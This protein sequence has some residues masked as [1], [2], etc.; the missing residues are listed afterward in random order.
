[1]KRQVATIPE[2]VLIKGEVT[3]T[4]DLTVE[5]RVEGKIGLDRHALTIGPNGRVEAEVL[6]KIV[7]VMGKV[8]GDISATDTI[9]ILKTA[10][11][12]GAIGAPRVGIE[13]G[14]SFRGHIDISVRVPLQNVVRW[15]KPEKP[16]MRLLKRLIGGSTSLMRREPDPDLCRLIGVS[17][18]PA[19]ATMRL[20]VESDSQRERAS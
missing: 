9:N 3:A 4:Q 2:S 18:K 6:A 11:V 19:E 7:N 8:D 13:E 14:A 10:T 16:H 15:L 20:Q 12:D 1:M 5:G 17:P